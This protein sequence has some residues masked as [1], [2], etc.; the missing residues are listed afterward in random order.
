MTSEVLSI[1]RVPILG[2]AVSFYCSRDCREASGGGTGMRG[3]GSGNSVRP[4]DLSHSSWP[5]FQGELPSG[6]LNACLLSAPVLG[7]GT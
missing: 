6:S 4:T 2:T 1:L 3:R 7:G 5:Q